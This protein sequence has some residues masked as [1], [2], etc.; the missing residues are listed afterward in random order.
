MPRC[1]RNELC[2]VS[3]APRKLKDFRGLLVTTLRMAVSGDFGLTPAT[4]DLKP[5]WVISFMAGRRPEYLR[6]N[7]KIPATLGV[8]PDRW[9]R[10]IRDGDETDETLILN[11]VPDY[12]GD[13]R[14]LDTL[15]RE[16]QEEVANART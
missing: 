13:K 8:W 6:H 15:W 1:K 11:G 3:Y 4:E 5:W 7:E 14:A 12:D 16:V 2:V 9:L 10:P